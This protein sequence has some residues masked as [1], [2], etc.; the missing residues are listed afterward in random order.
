MTIRRTTWHDLYY[1]EFRDL[2]FLLQRAYMKDMTRS[3]TT[4]RVL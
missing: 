2:A 3:Y 1:G 4:W